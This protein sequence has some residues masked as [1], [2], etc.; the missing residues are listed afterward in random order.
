MRIDDVDLEVQREPFARPFGFKGGYFHEKWNAVVRLRGEQGGEVYGVGGLAVLW[1]DAVVFAQ[2]TETGGNLL[3]LAVLE[4]ALQDVRGNAFSDPVAMTHSIFP[5]V[6]EYAVAVTRHAGLRRTFTRNA[7]VALDN[8]AWLLFAAERDAGRLDELIPAASRPALAERQARLAMVPLV[9]YT[10]PLSDVERLLASGAFF[11][12]IKIGQPGRE[13]EMLAKDQARLLEI[14]ERARDC[15]T[16]MTACGYP[17]YYLDANQRYTKKETLLRL[18]AFADKAGM[19]DRIALIEEPFAEE[20]D[21][22]VGDI[23]ARIA[24]DESLHDADDVQAKAARGYS[25][26]A[27]K[28]AG[29]TLSTAFEMA[30]AAHAQNLPCYVADNGCVPLLVDWNKNVAARLPAFPGVSCG[31]MESNGPETYP[32]WEEQLARHPCPAAS[33]LRPESGMF[34]LD[35]T[36]YER[37]GGMFEPPEFFAGCFR[38]VGPAEK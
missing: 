11:L 8:A 14:H 25:A 10:L 12:K 1:S 34:T 27:I 29:K 9:S 13:E 23:P 37:S 20:L 22:S 38:R 3:M 31:I 4:R 2:H 21:I 32:N 33:W 24:A 16:D 7:L 15:R 26:I 6:H 36:F 5:A 30:A 35:A 18:L 19:A 28:P 17:L